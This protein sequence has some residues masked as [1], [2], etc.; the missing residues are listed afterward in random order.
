MCLHEVYSEQGAEE[1]FSG[2]LLDTN[3][4]GGFEFL[5]MSVIFGRVII[6]LMGVI[7]RVTHL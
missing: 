3:Y 4:P 1:N 5:Q 7:T 2:V 6:P